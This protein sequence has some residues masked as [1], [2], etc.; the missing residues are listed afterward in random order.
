[1]LIIDA[2]F[3][4]TGTKA[5]TTLKAHLT[6]IS[7]PFHQSS[8]SALKIGETSDRYPALAIRMSTGPTA[9]LI[10]W[11]AASSVFLFTTSAT[12]VYNLVFGYS[13]E[14]CSLAWRRFFSVRPKME[15]LDAPDLANDRAI[16]E[17][18][19]VPPPEITMF[20]PLVESCGKVG[21]MAGYV[22]V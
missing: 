13:F 6:L 4:A 22:S 5:F 10:D 2:F 3:A 11:K 8:K 7:N 15:M 17:P 14:S 21:S 12:Y 9:V 16:S 19:P 20:L 1:M 18:I